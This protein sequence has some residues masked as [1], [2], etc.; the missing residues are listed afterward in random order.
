MIRKMEDQYGDKITFEPAPKGRNGVL[1]TFD[2]DQDTTQSMEFDLADLLK[3][4]MLA[5]Q[6]LEANDST[7]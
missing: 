7:D 1:V 3:F 6:E 2:E 5:L 4:Q